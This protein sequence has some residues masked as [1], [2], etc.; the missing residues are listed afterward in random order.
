MAVQLLSSNEWG[1]AVLGRDRQAKGKQVLV[2]LQHLVWW[3]SDIVADADSWFF[4]SHLILHATLQIMYIV[5]NYAKF[6]CL[7][8]PLWLRY[9]KFLNY[10]QTLVFSKNKNKKQKKPESICFA[11]ICPCPL[12]P[13]LISQH[14]LFKGMFTQNS[15][16]YHE[17]EK[18]NNTVLR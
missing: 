7:Q 3:G 16:V 13:L 15:V 2:F 4:R 11:N 8:T 1:A 9:L 10:C 14:Y 12:T 6:R 17:I 18:W 5:W